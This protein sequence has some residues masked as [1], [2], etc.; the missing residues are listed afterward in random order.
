[1]KATIWGARGSQASPGADT[2][3]YGG[4]TSCIK[5]EAR[6]DSRVVLDAGT[7]LRLV[8]VGLPPEVRRVDILLTH[9]HMD[10]IQGLGF[11]APLFVE[12]F[13]VHIWGPGS[14]TADL[15]S[16]LTRY[17]SP[18]LFPVRLPE[19]PCD[20][21]LHDLKEGSIEVPGITVTARLVCHPGPTVGY[22]LVGDTGTLTYL[23]DHEPFLACRQF[24]AD[25]EW[26]SGLE[27]AAGADV[28]IHDAQYTDEEYT[29]RIGWVHSTLNHALAFA[30]LARVK[31][32]LAFH[33]DPA[34]G[35]ATLD[36]HFAAGLRAEEPFVFTPVRE[37]MT[38][39]IG[40]PASRE[41]SH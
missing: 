12:G 19:L 10:H 25:P 11:F 18:P 8:G 15:R 40:A 5:V 33:H 23:P 24:A 38:F 28:L 41:A 20:L 14:S 27:L 4:N 3:R 1:V 34:H 13:E 35:D 7:G 37:G 17:M 9:L 6:P 39:E 16:R 32:L 36:D 22:R 2:I 29:E 21:H 31:Q 30:R 26:C